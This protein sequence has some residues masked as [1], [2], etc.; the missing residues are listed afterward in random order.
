MIEACFRPVRSNS[1]FEPGT[2]S[3]APSR[4]PMTCPLPATHAVASRNFIRS[5]K[6]RVRSGFFLIRYFWD[7]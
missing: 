5:C 7:M 1:L 4:M 2:I 6:G 3:R